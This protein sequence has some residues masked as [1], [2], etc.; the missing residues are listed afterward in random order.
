LP[1][2]LPRFDLSHLRGDLFG[3]LTAAIV[4]LPL[5]LAFGVASGAGPV[6]GLYGAICVGL[7]ASLFGGTP[8]Q[9]SG[10]T[11]P[12]TVVAATVFTAH[13]GNPA[14]AFTIV[15][16][17]GLLQVLFGKLRLGRYINLVPYPVI[18]GFMSGIG[19]IIIVMQ[20]D[21][22]LG[23][24]APKS[25]INALTVLPEFLRHPVPGALAAGSLAL[26]ICLFTPKPV[27]QKV[28][29]TLVALVT[30][31]LLVAFFFPG[32]P[33]LGPI[34]S[35]LPSLVVPELDL[36]L[37]REV[38]PPALVLAALGS[39]D[40]LLTSLIADNVTR[41]F[42]DSDREL[43]G[44]GIGNVAAGL[45]GGIPGAGATIRT[46]VNIRSGGRTPLSGM[47]HAVVLLAFV[48]GLGPLAAYVPHA[49]LAGILIKVGID[50]ID[51][52]YLKRAHRLPVSA[53]VCMATVLLLTVFVDVVT[54][55]A[56]GTIMASMLFIAEMA[57]LQS[58][59]IRA[60][61]DHGSGEGILSAAEA[62]LF[63]E[64]QGRVLLLH[65]SGPMS[66]GAANEMTRRMSLARTFDVLVVDMQDVP[67]LDVSAALALETIIQR[68]HDA[69]QQVVLAGI[70]KP[71]ARTLVQVG[72]N[73]TLKDYDH[74]MTRERALER[75][76]EL[77]AGG[78]PA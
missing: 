35:A 21:P 55:V 73:R 26:A 3:G 62:A 52:S 8:A 69:G 33:V 39:L 29:A 74:Y 67:T 25:V 30:G 16:L 28:P 50:V 58:Q 4:A 64:L 34:P 2:A 72:L 76:R 78:V 44:Q 22:L 18:S 23:H 56:V 6:A 13:A 61:T 47:F 10:P 49:V 77:V 42:H 37:L 14:I 9:V 51:W 12:M 68:A 1:A 43:V 59:S 66:F 46:L 31:T 71:V 20:L 70:H 40:S 38:I 63:R 11:G 17:A 65:L 32:V 19:V 75:A 24:D 5:A 27:T 57:D 60:I 48:L 36:R 54:A 41:T 7:F 15:M 45:L 53:T